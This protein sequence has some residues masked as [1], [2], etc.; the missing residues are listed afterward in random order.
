MW[1]SEHPGISKEALSDILRLE[2]SEVLPTG[3]ELPSSFADAM[4]LVVPFLIQPILF[5]ACPN[6]S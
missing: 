2:H 4:K 6:D 3:N 5:H 1:L